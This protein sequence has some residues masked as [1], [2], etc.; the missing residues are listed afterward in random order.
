MKNLLFF[1]L[2]I[3]LLDSCTGAF[4]KEIG[5]VESLNKIVLEAEKSVLSLDTG[6]I[7]A[8]K[9]QLA[10]DIKAME[11]ITDTLS[12]EEIFAM[13]GYMEGKK[14]LYNFVNNYN[15]YLEEIEF[16]KNQLDNLKTDL[17]NS[18]ITKQ[19]FTEYYV[20]EQSEVM[21]LTTKVN[22]TVG[23]LEETVKR[24]KLERERVMTLLE[25]KQ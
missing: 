25:S 4:D 9:R 18:K 14:R 24:M 19:E 16:A 22:G 20:L 11:S 13:T 21:K 6:E 7:F 17:E 2:A 15:N 1:I 5:E 8:V 12:R 3:A 23:G 10:L